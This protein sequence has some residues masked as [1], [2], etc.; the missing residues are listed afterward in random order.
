VAYE[1]GTLS[2]ILAPALRI[3]Y[4]IGRGGPLVKALIQR[5]SDAGFSAPL[6]TQ[7]MAS[8]LLDHYVG[9]QIERVCAGYRE[10]AA[11]TREWIDR[12]LGA[13]LA[14]CRG[15]RAGFYF[16]LTFDR[17]ETHEGSAFFRFLTRT[18]GR[19]SVDGPAGAKRPRVL[20]IPGEFCVHPRGELVGEGRRQLRLSYGFEDLPRIGRAIELMGEATAFAE[21]FVPPSIA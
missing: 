8:Y 7:E 15:G 14:S 11:R 9:E 13:R 19:E 2:K 12:H 6:V 16:Y 10:K 5:T 4:L 21:G 18:T 1:I 17:I 20:Y 3:G